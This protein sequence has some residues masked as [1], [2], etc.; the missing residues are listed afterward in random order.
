MLEV[1]YLPYVFSKRFSTKN[2]IPLQNK[3]F[4]RFCEIVKLLWFKMILYHIVTLSFK[5][6]R[7]SLLVRSLDKKYFHEKHFRQSVVRF[8]GLEK[9]RK[10]FTLT[11]SGK[12][13]IFAQ[14]WND[15]LDSIEIFY[16]REMRDSAWKVSEKTSN[17]LWDT[18]KWR[19]ERVEAL[20]FDSMNRR[21]VRKKPCLGTD[22]FLK[23]EAAR[24]ACL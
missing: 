23:K 8:S 5:C 20:C 6:K 21:V 7:P 1:F 13:N 12:Q 17:R 4:E 14:N 10:T 24:R 18:S 19:L 2:L 15:S 9:L 22:H 16:M 11:C 3:V